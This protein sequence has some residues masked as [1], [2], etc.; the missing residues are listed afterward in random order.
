[1]KVHL[2][3]LICISEE[4][5]FNMYTAVNK[6]NQLERN[7]KYTINLIYYFLIF[8]VRFVIYQHRNTKMFL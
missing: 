4:I 5:G 6:L 8:A 2:I 1:M 7:C 3:T